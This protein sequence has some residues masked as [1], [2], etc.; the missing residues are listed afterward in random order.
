VN[1]R[2]RSGRNYSGCYWVRV[3]TSQTDKKE[4]DEKRSINNCRV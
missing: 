4:K 1:G 3:V 2:S